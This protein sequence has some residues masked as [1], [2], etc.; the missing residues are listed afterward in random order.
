MSI[1]KFTATQ[2]GCISGKKR[3]SFSTLSSFLL[4]HHP[5]CFSLFT[6][7]DHLFVSLSS[8]HLQ[9]LL[10]PPSSPISVFHSLCCPMSLSHPCPWCQT[11][12]WGKAYHSLRRGCCPGRPCGSAAES[13]SSSAAASAAPAS[14]PRRI[15][16]R[17][18]R[19]R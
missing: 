1:Q 9:S 13:V 4:S 17:C 14:A 3:I 2:K 8:S 16:R 19:W 11:T 15:V 18:G 5:L 6:L 12:L 7:S 10:Y